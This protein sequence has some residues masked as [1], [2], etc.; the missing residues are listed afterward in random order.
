MADNDNKVAPLSGGDSEN[1]MRLMARAIK[2]IEEVDSTTHKADDSL[3]KYAS[4]FDKLNEA[5]GASIKSLGEFI[6]VLKSISKAYPSGAELY[7]LG[8]AVDNLTSK[9]NK[10]IEFS[11]ALDN[12]G[13]FK[14]NRSSLESITSFIKQL[15]RIN[16]NDDI[17]DITNTLTNLNKGINGLAST[18]VT[19]LKNTLE[20]LIL[21]FD[22]LNDQAKAFNL[23]AISNTLSTAGN[24]V[25]AYTDSI[26]QLNKTLKDFAKTSADIKKAKFDKVNLTINNRGSDK[27]S[28]KPSK[29]NI[30][31]AKQLKELQDSTTKALGAGHDLLFNAV[32]SLG[33]KYSKVVTSAIDKTFSVVSKGKTVAKASKE[34]A[35]YGVEVGVAT[36]G[37][38]GLTKGLT[39]L[40]GKSVVVT[41]VIGGVA[42]VLGL[43]GVAGKYAYDRNQ[44]LNKS[45]MQLGA[46][47][48]ELTDVTSN[49]A[50]KV[51]SIKNTWTRIGDDLAGAFD[52]FYS[53]VVDFVDFLSKAVEGIT[54]PLD[55]DNKKTFTNRDSILRWY[56][57]NLEDI[58]GEP[59]NKSVPAISNIASSAKQSGFDSSSAANLGIGTYDRAIALARKYGVE[60]SKVAEQLADA[61]LNGS[62]AAKEYGV[63]VD[64]QVLA[65]YMATKGVD[66]VNVK[67][68]DAMKQYYRYQLML[69][70]SA[71][72]NDSAMQDQIKAWKQLGFIIDS[73]KGKLFSF[74]E[75]INLSA[76]DPKIPTVG[77][78][79]VSYPPSEGGGDTSGG[80]IPP[81]PPVG[82]TP[83]PTA[84]APVVIP[85]R[86]DVVEPIPEFVPVPINIPVNI[87]GLDLVPE[88]VS[89]LGLVY[90][91]NPLP[92]TVPV[93]VPG[94]E[95]IPSLQGQL[96]GLPNNVP[97]SVP[98]TVPGFDLVPNLLTYC[99][100]LAFTPWMATIG[101]TIPMLNLLPQALGYCYELAK[102]WSAKVNIS[103]VGQ[104]ALQTAYNLLNKVKTLLSQLGQKVTSGATTAYNKVHNVVT[105]IPGR[106]KTGV[107]NTVNNTKAKVNAF[108]AGFSGATNTGGL[109]DSWAPTS[110]KAYGGGLFGDIK[111]DLDLN[112]VRL[113]LKDSTKEGYTRQ[114]INNAAAGYIGYNLNPLNKNSATNLMAKGTAASAV[115]ATGLSAVPKAAGAISAGAKGALGAIQSGAA[116]FVNSLGGATGGLAFT[117][118]FANG[119]IG[120]KEIH[121]AT[122][123]EDNKKEAV[124]PLESNAGIRY[125][126]DA[127]KQAGLGSNNGSSITINLTLSGVNIADNEAQW[128][129]VGKK[130]AEVIDI[131]KQ[132]R[133]ELNYGSSF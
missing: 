24:G 119:G 125:L 104:Q 107:T 56:T 85:V 15:E 113:G 72:D 99:Q 27:N 11:R 90:A 60:A 1:F 124:I 54:A 43:M 7:K 28:S 94:L 127:L 21:S 93:T 84:P 86:Y 100:R 6:T 33:G 123:F 114:Q 46:N 77:T 49:T 80:I 17:K 20:D 132:R 108:G 42:L 128:E 106:V 32:N 95:Y 96:Q 2:R 55:E 65:G 48:S 50:N 118:A 97:V 64:D 62:E 82:T 69:E 75:V 117:P 8:K 115:I 16:L 78:P 83:T 25:K 92:V 102:A 35:K 68:T 87:P 67:I 40:A 4:H 76:V 120:T 98:V 53:V 105:S 47:N 79:S 29:D 61:W 122:L 44:E 31:A 110:A 81:I 41:G 9:Q 19:K 111:A 74:D 52:G 14:F 34:I 30:E 71:N 131:Q 59:E 73:T 36:K 116:G 129:R 112:S 38:T 13:K 66:I 130:I 45:L 3:V 88:L 133:G 126:S 23:D 10:L 37:T 57:K 18:D 5:A 26:E 89:G 103:V 51:I 58:S 63:V 91:L 109:L 121:N 12:I 70:Q 101:V 39:A 22:D